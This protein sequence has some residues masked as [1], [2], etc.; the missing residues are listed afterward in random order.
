[1]AIKLTCYYIVSFCL[2]SWLM[3]LSG[4]LT[5]KHFPYI[6]S[7]KKKPEE[8]KYP[9]YVRLSLDKKQFDIKSEFQDF[10]LNKK[11]IH[12]QVLKELNAF[13]ESEFDSM[14]KLNSSEFTKAIEAERKVIWDI[15]DYLRNKNFNVVKKGAKVILLQFITPVEDVINKTCLPLLKKSLLI[16]KELKNGQ[17]VIGIIDWNRDFKSVL[18]GLEDLSKDSIASSI[19]IKF[20]YASNLISF[21]SEFTTTLIE[22]KSIGSTNENLQFQENVIHLIDNKILSYQWYYYDLKSKFRDYLTQKSIDN[23]VIEEYIS[24]VD[25]SLNNEIKDL[26]LDNLQEAIF[27][28]PAKMPELSLI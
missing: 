20:K 10:L 16:S 1:M 28:L 22:K 15:S 27:P 17:A 19:I 6:D 21:L 5:I 8:G 18:N 11:G 25:L 24:I 2:I 4:K 23:R 26:P 13:T 14:I 12:P 9:V 7:R 3:D